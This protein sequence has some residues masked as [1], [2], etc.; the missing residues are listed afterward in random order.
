MQWREVA[1]RFPSLPGVVIAL[2][3]FALR[4]YRRSPVWGSSDAADLPRLVDHLLCRPGSVV[5]DLGDL[6]LYRLGGVQPV[7][8]YLQ[9]SVLR[10]LGVRVGEFLWDLPELLAGTAAIYVAYL[11]GRQLA[12]RSA[13]VT[14]AA[15]I[16]VS[17]MAIMQ[18]RHSGAPWMF[19]ELLQ[20]VI[21]LLS[22]KLVEAPTPRLRVGFHLALACYFWAGNQM[23]GIV[24]VV[25]YAVACVVFA[26]KDAVRRALL[27]HFGGWT[28]V[29]PVASLLVLLYLTF[30]LRIGHLAHALFAKKHHPGFYFAHWL[31][32]M[33]VDVGP[34]ITWM[35]LSVLVLWTLS[36]KGLLTPA[37]SL[38]VLFVAYA[39]PFWVLIPPHST[40]TRGYITYGLHALL[41]VLA[42][43]AARLRLP[44]AARLSL[45]VLAGVILLCESSQSVFR[46]FSSELIGVK[47]FQGS[48]IPNSGVKSAAGWIRKQPHSEGRVF[49]D[50]SGGSG[51][52]PPLMAMYFRLPY[53]AEFDAS[54]PSHPYKV[55]ARRKD[56]IDY[57]V[58]EPGNR[59]LVDRFFG[60]DFKEAA[61]IKDGKEQLLTVFARQ[62]QGGV[63]DVDVAQ[64]DRDFGRSFSLLCGG[65]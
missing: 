7:L 39:L 40:L 47:G 42:V 64:G 56:E 65:P 63:E 10:L 27:R 15:L 11:L 57:L 3:G 37:R 2:L 22:L 33:A 4:V 20:L 14:A 62:H 18:S 51:L 23:L 9:M 24:P 30:A 54:S 32:D 21:L 60:E 29:V 8:L 6:A 13:G 25:A 17:P 34:A 49:S 35:A 45:P 26:E 44:L 36:E 58:I 16:A 48:F 19:E 46:V 28:L 31:D 52:E 41:L 1:K 38:L 5:S 59:P 43:G 12:T 61:R 50:A 55:F 53:L